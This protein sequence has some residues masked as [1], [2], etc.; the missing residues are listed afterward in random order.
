MH[1]IYFNFELPD[2]NIEHKVIFCRISLCFLYTLQVSLNV[3]VS[4]FISIVLSHSVIVNI[5]ISFQFNLIILL[6]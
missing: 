6:F 5:Y 2:C 3:V 1:T 4:L